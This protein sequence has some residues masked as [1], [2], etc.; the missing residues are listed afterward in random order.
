MIKKNIHLVEVLFDDNEENK[1]DI[2]NCWEDVDLASQK[3]YRTSDK[4]FFHN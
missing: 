2:K 4:E 1:I 3:P